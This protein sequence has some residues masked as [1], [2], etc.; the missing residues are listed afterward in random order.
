[1]FD[2]INW[3]FKKKLLILSVILFILVIIFI[4]LIL[5]KSFN[6][7]SLPE[8][9]R[10]TATPFSVRP[11]TPTTV[12][13]SLVPTEEKID[14]KGVTIKNIYRDPVEVHGNGDVVFYRNSDYQ[15]VY[16]PKFSNFHITVLGSPFWDKAK[17]A[18]EQF[19][20]S[21]DISK[22]QACWLTV[23]IT[24]PQFANE[25]YAGKTFP[26]SYCMDL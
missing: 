7:A 23:E 19:I 16:L 8:I 26:L 5:V 9:P 17:E 15:L 22:E 14:I 24:T 2:L 20:K 25:E 4:I 1:M 12:N 18:E 21:L 10:P 13:L 3:P 11:I 6:P